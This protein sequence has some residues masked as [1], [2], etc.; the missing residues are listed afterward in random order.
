LLKRLCVHPGV[1]LRSEVQSARNARQAHKDGRPLKHVREARMGT[2]GWIIAILM[3]AGC[4]VV[5]ILLARW[6]FKN[7]YRVK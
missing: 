1:T 2:T 3:S 5:V 6:V 7:S 4:S